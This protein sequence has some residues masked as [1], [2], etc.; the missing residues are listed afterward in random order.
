MEQYQDIID[1]LLN[2]RS[3]SE[4]ES[5]IMK[6]DLEFKAYQKEFQLVTLGIKK[7]A[8]H[9][10]LEEI[11]ALE[12]KSNSQDSTKP[13]SRRRWLLVLGLILLGGLLYLFVQLNKGGSYDKDLLIADNVVNYPDIETSRSNDVSSN[14]KA[15][16]LYKKGKHP[17]A[18]K[19]FEKLLKL[20]QNPKHK[21]YLG[22]SLM[23]EG[24]YKAAQNIFEHESL[25]GYKKVPLNYY[26]ALCNIANDEPDKAVELLSNPTLP[27]PILDNK[28]SKI[29]RMLT[30]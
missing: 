25:N 22:V 16:E 14:N 28:R 3:L 29:I 9:K 24:R 5:K 30:R 15:Y 8:L 1:K 21:F 4:S 7:S 23:Q 11:K 10:K 17:E 27:S 2:H 19:E 6:N 26:L 13:K 20:D 18:I 12:A